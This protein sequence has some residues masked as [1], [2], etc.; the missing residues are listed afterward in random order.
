MGRGRTAMRRPPRGLLRSFAALA[1]GVLPEG[2][3]LPPGAVTTDV[4]GGLA[5]LWPDPQ[6]AARR[7]CEV[8]VIGSGAGGAVVAATLAEAGRE[9]IVLEEGPMVTTTEIRTWSIAERLVRLYRDS[10][11]SAALGLPPL[12]LPMGRCVGGTTTVNSGT[13][14]ATPDSVLGAWAAGRLAELQPARLPPPL[15]QRA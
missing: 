12:A 3:A 5:R 7:D 15:A 9:V 11:M 13:C 4:A 1:E 10:G 6:P 14:F 8:L 2:G